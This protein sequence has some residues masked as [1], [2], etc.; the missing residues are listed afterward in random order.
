VGPGRWPGQSGK[1]LVFCQAISASG[2]GS[3]LEPLDAPFGS[4]LVGETG[5]EHVDSG[6]LRGAACGKQDRG[7][8]G[9][10]MPDWKR[11]SGLGDRLHALRTNRVR[12]PSRSGSRPPQPPRIAPRRGSAE[13]F[14]QLHDVVGIAVSFEISEPQVKVRRNEIWFVW[15]D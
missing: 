15:R 14:F 12:R 10:S 13:R 9:A 5:T 8:T 6:M 7:Q 3:S 2:D 11:G 1:E 4:S